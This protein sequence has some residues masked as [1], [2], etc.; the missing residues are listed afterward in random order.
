[1]C[2]RKNNIFACIPLSHAYLL[3]YGVKL[4]KKI[5]IYIKIYLKKCIS[6]Y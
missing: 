6:K 1:M 2:I 4:L 5:T 3:N